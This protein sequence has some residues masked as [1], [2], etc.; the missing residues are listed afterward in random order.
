MH[1][2]TSSALPAADN[3]RQTVHHLL[4]N[5]HFLRFR[6]QRVH[7]RNDFPHQARNLHKARKPH[8]TEKPHSRSEQYLYKTPNTKSKVGQASS[9]RRCLPES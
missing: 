1:P 2:D 4:Y 3:E 5:I 7:V 9:E 8:S 6:L